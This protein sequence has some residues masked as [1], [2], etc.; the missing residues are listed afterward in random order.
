VA[1]CKASAWRPDG[2]CLYDHDDDRAR[3][4][5]EEGHADR[6]DI[7]HQALGFGCVEG[8]VWTGDER[9][10]MLA[11]IDGPVRVQNVD[12]PK[13]EEPDPADWWKD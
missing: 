8:T 3:C 13:D 5:L 1:R 12:P 6:G 4:Q 10:L 2:Q 11:W 7:L 9:E